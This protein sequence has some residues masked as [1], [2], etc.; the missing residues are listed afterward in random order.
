MALVIAAN[1][2]IVPKI[3]NFSSYFDLEIWQN[4]QHPLSQV[5]SIQKS[6]LDSKKI[7]CMVILTC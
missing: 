3:W 2:A 4:K 7:I 1:I 5:L 6:G